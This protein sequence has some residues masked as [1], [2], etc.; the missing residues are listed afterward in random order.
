[1]IRTASF[2]SV[3][4]RFVS[5]QFLGSQIVQVR[6]ATVWRTLEPFW[7]EE[8]NLTVFNTASDVLTLTVFDEEKRAK[9]EPVFIREKGILIFFSS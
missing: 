4:N 3:R 7:G 1:V 6:T 2:S 9:D 8:Y 5:V